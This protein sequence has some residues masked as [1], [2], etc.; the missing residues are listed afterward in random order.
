MKEGDI[1]LVS[2]PKKGLY[3]KIVPQGIRWF[4]QFEYHHAALVGIHNDEL[5]IYESV[6]SGFK[7]TK[8][9]AEYERYIIEDGINIKRIPKS[10]SLN[11]TEFRK[12][13]FELVGAPY[14]FM[15]LLIWHPI[16]Q[17]SKRFGKSWWFGKRGPAA[18]N[19]SVCTESIAY[20][21]GIPNWWTYT[22]KDLYDY[23]RNKI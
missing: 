4:T 21:V 14:D 8:S 20:I 13:L 11:I 9:L 3:N 18:K 7:P 5:W 10:R 2:K 1:I 15:S 12:R 23:Y 22:A 17:L 16:Y 6:F 19:K